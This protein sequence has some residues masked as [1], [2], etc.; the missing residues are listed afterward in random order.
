MFRIS[1]IALSLLIFL[2]FIVKQQIPVAIGYFYLFINLFTFVVYAI[3]KSAA[4]HHRWRIKE[5]YLHCLASLGGWWGALIAQQ[6]IRHKSI[7]PPFLI[8]FTVTMMSN[9]ILLTCLCYKGVF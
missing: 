9:I 7:K 1:F 2:Q 8:V 4:I 6:F 3:D 5:L